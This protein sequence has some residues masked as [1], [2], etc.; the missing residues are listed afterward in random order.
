MKQEEPCFE[1]ID[2]APRLPG[3]Y[4]YPF[5]FVI[6]KEIVATMKLRMDHEQAK[7]DIRYFFLCQVAPRN[8]VD[9]AD[10]G[11]SSLSCG[12]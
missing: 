8:N 12:K 9:M 4:R 5:S 6:P 10:N 2:G 7:L 11:L 3:N 1:F